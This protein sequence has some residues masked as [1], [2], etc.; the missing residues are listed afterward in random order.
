MSHIYVITGQT[1]TGKTRSALELAKQVNGELVNAD[2][3]Q[4]YQKLNVVTGKDIP[5]SAS[6]FEEPSLSPDLRLYR[7]GYYRS[8]EIPLWLYD[9]VDANQRFSAYDYVQCTLPV[10]RHILKQGK[11]P[12]I[13]GGTYLYLH[14]LLYG[15]D[16]AVKPDWKLRKELEDKTVEQLRSLIEKKSVTALETLN[17]SDSN[18]PHR[19]VRLLEILQ[20]NPMYKPKEP[21]Y[22]LTINSEIGASVTVEIKGYRHES[23]E[24]LEH[25]I[26][27]RVEKRL[28]QGAEEE[29]RNLLSSGYTIDSPGLQS[30]GYKELLDY[31]YQKHTLE[32]AKKKWIT[33]EIQYEKRQYTFM[34][35]NH[36]IQWNFSS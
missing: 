13:I 16:N 7:V 29:A 5:P 1:A 27:Q 3:R 11:T 12:I 26:E 6:F 33:R 22:N 9:I 24:T 8:D 10:L 36:H 14:T 21:S 30:I 34:K 31:T 28:E 25:A 23:R 17:N 19:L 15:A 32:E 18:N 2:S 4:I 35:K 20:S